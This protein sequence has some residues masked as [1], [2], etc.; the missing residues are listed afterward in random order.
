MSRYAR[1]RDKNHGEL[2]RAF[3]QLGCSVADLSGAGIPGWPD[4][5]VGVAGR[6]HLVEF[7]NPETRYGRAGLNDNQQAF[8]RD[9]RGGKLYAVSTVQEVAALVRNLKADGWSNR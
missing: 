5:V 4:V 1:R 3:E 9:W 7:K 6:N 2:Q 8:A